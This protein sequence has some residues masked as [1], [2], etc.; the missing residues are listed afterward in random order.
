MLSQHQG[1]WLLVTI[2]ITNIALQQVIVT[3]VMRRGCL[4][5]SKRHVDDKRSVVGVRRIGFRPNS[6]HS[7][8]ISDHG[9]SKGKINLVVK[10]KIKIFLCVCHELSSFLSHCTRWSRVASLKNQ[11]LNLRV[12][13]PDN[14]HFFVMWTKVSEPNAIFYAEFKYVISVLY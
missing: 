10:V 8:L 13:V 7:S 14:F 9:D 5:Q 6:R 3:H 2:W 11:A 1:Q 4:C 12:N